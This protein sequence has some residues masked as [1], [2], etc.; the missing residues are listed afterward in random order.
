MSNKGMGGVKMDLDMTD[1]VT[2]KVRLTQLSTKA[3]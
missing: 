3:G 1:K 2:E